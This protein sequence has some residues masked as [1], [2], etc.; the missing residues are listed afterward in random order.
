MDHLRD[1]DQLK[2]TNLG[3]AADMLLR[4]TQGLQ[5]HPKVETLVGRIT[6][7]DLSTASQTWTIT[8]SS[9]PSPVQTNRL[10]LCTGSSPLPPPLSFSIYPHLT[11]LHLDSCLSPT[12]LRQFFSLPSLS[13][14]SFNSTEMKD[15]RASPQSVSNTSMKEIRIGV[16][17]SSHSAI[18]V[19]MN[20]YH[21]STTSPYP[22][23]KVKWFTRH[24]LRYA[25]EMD[26]WILR[27]NT[28]LKGEA[29]TWARENL[30]PG[31]LEQSDV[32]KV[33]R[34]VETDAERRNSKMKTNG[35]H[36]TVVRESEEEIY[37]KELDGCE[38]VVYAIGYSKDDIP[39]ISI[40]KKQVEGL[41]FD[42]STGSFSS[43]RQQ[44]EGVRKEKVRGLYGGGIAFPER[45]TDPHGNVEYAVGFWKFMKFMKRASVDWN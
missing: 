24:A 2:G 34:A 20:L 3:D 42:H 19:L 17:G 25:E 18:L 44:S 16:I 43:T 22:V 27:D 32:G 30:E 28:G 36:E 13:S 40:D 26:G 45:V 7:A 37:A 39:E 14:Q 33:I 31:N 12:R 29:A 4:L 21:L 10:I 38:Y 1:L 6:K 5:Q 15:T 9:L 23:V 11:P 35:G 8:T 41:K